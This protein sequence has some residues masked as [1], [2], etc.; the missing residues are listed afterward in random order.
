MRPQVFET[1][2]KVILRGPYEA[3]RVVSDNTAFQNPNAFY[4]DAHQLYINSG[5]ER[6]WDG[7]NRPF[8]WITNK[9]TGVREL[10]ADRGWMF[11]AIRILKQFGWDTDLS[12]VLERP[13]KGIT[14]HDID[15]GILNSPFKLDQN[16]RECVAAWLRFAIGRCTV[17]V[18]GGK[19]ALFSAVAVK[20]R[21]KYPDYPILYIT[22]SERLVKQ[23]YRDITQFVP[24]ARVTRYGGGRESKDDPG[25]DKSGDIVVATTAMIS[26]NCKAARL[27]CRRKRVEG[28]L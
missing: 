24:A 5:G 6:G 9:K 21:E 4:S 16:Q 26:R 13:F 27:R 14:H 11:K 20:I 28:P 17:T 2:T 18:S 1:S 22:Y 25:N 15:P 8:Q 10:W 7:L 3:L 12:G 23:A 19:T